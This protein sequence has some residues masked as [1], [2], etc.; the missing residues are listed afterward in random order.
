L[1]LIVVKDR[2]SPRRQR[3]GGG[4]WSASRYPFSAS[5]YRP[6]W[7]AALARASNASLL[8]GS[9]EQP[10]SPNAIREKPRAKNP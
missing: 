4:H 2:Q 3:V 7:K 9:L 8:S 1:P 5:L 10:P 6:A